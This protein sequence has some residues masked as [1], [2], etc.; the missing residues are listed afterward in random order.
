M[1]THDLRVARRAKRKLR[2]VKGA[3]QPDEQ[4]ESRPEEESPVRRPGA[5]AG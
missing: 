1:V 3:V 4:I 5:L 2:L